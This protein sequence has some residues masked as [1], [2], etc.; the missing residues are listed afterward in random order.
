MEIFQLYRVLTNL[1]TICWAIK[2]FSINLKE[3]KLIKNDKKCV[4]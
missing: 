3:F 4:L 1:H 2:Q